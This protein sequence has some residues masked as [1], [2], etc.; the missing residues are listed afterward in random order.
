[1]LWARLPCPC[2]GFPPYLLFTLWP[3]PTSGRS[4]S[5]SQLSAAVSA[6]STHMSRTLGECAILPALPLSL[7]NLVFKSQ[8]KN[9]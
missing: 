4:F 7:T 5:E 9:L 1:M 8:D 6:L 3:Q 2:P